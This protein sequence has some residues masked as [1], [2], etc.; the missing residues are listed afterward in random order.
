MSATAQHMTQSSKK[1][2]AHPTSQLTDEVI[3][4]GPS[5][6]QKK[7]GGASSVSTMQGY[8][9]ALVHLYTTNKQVLDPA[10]NTE[11]ESLIKGYK[12][13]VATLKQS[14]DMEIQEGK[15]AISFISYRMIAH[16]LAVFT[17]ERESTSAA[18]FAWAFFVLQW[19]LIARSE[20]ITAILLDHLCWTQDS[21]L[22]Y[23]PKHKADQEGTHTLSIHCL[24]LIHHTHS[25]AYS[26]M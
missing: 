1:R 24:R 2:K 10:L 3:R 18:A 6:R 20:S 5:K 9:S 21:L 16:K 14:G 11:L 23:I 17:D 13:T 22:I 15:E 19:N 12:R 7:N 26:R 25:H 4:H 8:K